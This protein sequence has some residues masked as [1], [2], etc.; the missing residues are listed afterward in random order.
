M[1]GLGEQGIEDTW[2]EYFELHFKEEKEAFSLNPTAVEKEKSHLP[3]QGSLEHRRVWAPQT[4]HK[5]RLLRVAFL[6][7]L[8]LGDPHSLVSGS[9]AV[10]TWGLSYFCI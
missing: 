9:T 10:R 8:A 3:V 6:R 1:I 2:G 4:L 5:T 7:A